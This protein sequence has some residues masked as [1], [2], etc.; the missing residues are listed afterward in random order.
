[1]PLLD[2]VTKTVPVVGIQKLTTID[3]PGHLAAVLFIGGCPWD[4]RYCHNPSLRSNVGNQVV[5][6][7]LHAFLNDR[8]GFLEGI[9]FSGGEPTEHHDLPE[10]IRWVRDFGYRTALHTNGSNP[11]TLRH[12]ILDRLV[13]YIAMDVKGPPRAYDRI[14]RARNSCVPAAKSIDLVASSGIDHEFRIT[15][16]PAL[17][18]EAELIETMQAMAGKRTSRFFIQLF[19]TEG[20]LDEEL[21]SGGDIVTV[22]ASAI[23]L[24]EKLFRDFG[25]R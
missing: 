6:E 25:V 13:D 5:P 11:E 2:E 18:S 1:M 17:L 7:E 19:R 14:T 16:H 9:V 24:G 10:L 23:M 22:P 20:V 21:A 4:C 12:I 15:Y 8:R 3:Y